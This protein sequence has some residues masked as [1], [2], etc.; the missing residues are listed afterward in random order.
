MKKITFF[1]I[2]I[3]FFFVFLIIVAGYFQFFGDKESGKILRVYSQKEE[4][5]FKIDKNRI[6]EIKGDIGITKIEI[7]DGSFRFID[8]PCQNKLCIKAGFVKINNYSVVCLPNKVSAYLCDDKNRERY[9]G[10]SR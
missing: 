2:I 7:K 3:T 9:D 8:S 1:D 10:I 4:Y 6:V 5:F